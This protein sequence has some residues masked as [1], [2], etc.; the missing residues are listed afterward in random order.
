MQR[1]CWPEDGTII[2]TGPYWSIPSGRNPYPRQW[3]ITPI[4]FTRGQY[5]QHPPMKT[6]SNG[7]IF[8]VPGHLCV[9]FTCHRWIPHTK[10][11]ELSFHV[12]FD[13]RQNK[14]LSKQS[15]GWWFETP[16][17]PLWRHYNASQR[18]AS[19]QPTQ[20]SIHH[21]QPISLFLFLVGSISNSLTHYVS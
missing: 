4:C 14:R 2:V 7:N 19:T 9:E 15:W 10:A 16:S 5:S 12:L 11:I 8:R 13:L 21:R 6:S 17:R 3:F 20:K 18:S 1:S